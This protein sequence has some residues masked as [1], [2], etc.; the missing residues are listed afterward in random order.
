MV[1]VPD[2][3]GLL[4]VSPEA[5]MDEV[6]RAYR[7]AALR[8][9]PDRNGNRAEAGERM[10]VVNEAWAVLRDAERRAEYDRRYREA[11]GAGGTG[12]ARVWVSRT[13]FT[14]ANWGR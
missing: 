11:Y 10:R 3:Y 2:Y 6:H 8:L 7:D 12:Q 4:G 9:H 5:G 13:V 14:S 1:S